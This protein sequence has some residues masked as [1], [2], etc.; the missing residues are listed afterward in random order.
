MKKLCLINLSL[1]LTA[2]EMTVL[3]GGMRSGINSSDYGLLSDSPDE[4]TND[5]F[6]TLLDMRVQWKLMELGI[7]QV[8][9][10]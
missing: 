4:L 2:P 1:G 7:L 9:T 6:K 10:E 8:L 3:L 5:Y